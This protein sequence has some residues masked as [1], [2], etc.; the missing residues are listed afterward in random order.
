MG[1]IQRREANRYQLNL[2]LLKEGKAVHHRGTKTVQSESPVSQK[3]LNVLETYIKRTPHQWYQWKEAGLLLGSD[4][5]QE[6]RPKHATE[7]DR[8]LP[9]EDTPVHAF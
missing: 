1:L 7:E 5:D 8:Y 2:H 4:V 6:R 3:A 9:L